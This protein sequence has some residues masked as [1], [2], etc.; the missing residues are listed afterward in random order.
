M[1]VVERLTLEAVNAHSLL[2]VEHTHRYELAAELCRGLRVLDLCCGSGYGSEILRATC[3]SVTGVD[4]DV[5]TVDMAQ[6]T[7]GRRTDAE[8][9]VADA[10]EYLRRTLDEEFDA[11]VLLEGLEH[12]ADPEDA[13][14]SLRRHGARGVKLVVSLPN[15]KAF[16]EVNPYHV[17]NYGYEEALE[18]FS[19]FD[20][21][22][23]L[24]QFLAEGSLIRGRDASEEGGRII[25][26]ERGEPEYANHF[27]ACVNFGESDVV[28]ESARMHLEVAP[29]HNRYVRNLERANE[30]LRR[31][32]AQLARKRLGK[33]D[34]AA[35]SLLAKLDRQAAQ[36]EA[37]RQELQ[38]MRDAHDP[39]R[40]AS[41]ERRALINR[42]EELHEQVLTQ[43]RQIRAMTETR[44]W[45]LAARYWRVR[46]GFRGRSTGGA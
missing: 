37:A 18:V 29:V 2:A 22:V 13:I 28:N 8:F 24:Y 42:V 35:A 10:H 12:L 39:E 32:N 26:T 5:P 40:H 4:N 14:S 46:D 25:A 21:V 7:V 15:S 3:R 44:V 23:V 41:A 6:A 9:E 45:R 20:D 16:D 38:K 33:A 11:I 1:G 30:E 31:I 27:I 43:D 36:L 34:S 19:Q 17:T